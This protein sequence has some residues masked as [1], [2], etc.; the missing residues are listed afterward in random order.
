MPIQAK[1]PIVLRDTPPSVSQAVNVEKTSRKGSPAEKA[2]LQK[3][4]IITHFNGEQIKYTSSLLPMVLSYQP[5]D[6]VILTVFREEEVVEITVTLG[7]I[8]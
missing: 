7:K 2:G 1:K 3:D 4:D 5:G 6:K 8:K